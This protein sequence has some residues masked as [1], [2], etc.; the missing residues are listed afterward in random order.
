MRDLLK[1][2]YYVG[3]MPEA[4][5]EYIQTNDVERLS[6]IFNSLLKGYNEDAEKFVKSEDQVKMLRHVLKVF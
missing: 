3:G 6:R 5:S 2:Y 1:K 4:V